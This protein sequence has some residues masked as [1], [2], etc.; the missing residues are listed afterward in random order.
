MDIHFENYRVLERGLRN[1]KSKLLDD[2]G[3]HRILTQPAYA[4]YICSKHTN[5]E[6]YEGKHIKETIVDID[7]F[8]RVRQRLCNPSL[9]RTGIKMI[10]NNEQ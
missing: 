7:T 6:V 2:N 8:Q 1:Y 3:I 5:Y 10:I 4:G 9:T